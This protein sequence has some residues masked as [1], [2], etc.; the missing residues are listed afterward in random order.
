MQCIGSP[1]RKMLE[2]AVSRG[3]SPMEECPE[4]MMGIQDEKGRA[5][6]KTR[7]GLKIKFA[8]YKEYYRSGKSI[9]WTDMDYI[10]KKF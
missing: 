6:S 1:L 8:L 7:S 2:I 9:F 10:L 5:K 3:K 4:I